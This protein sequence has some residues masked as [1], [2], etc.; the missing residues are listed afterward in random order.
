[1]QKILDI[2]QTYYLYTQI[3][4][5]ERD[6]ESTYMRVHIM[7]L[8]YITY[9][10]TYLLYYEGNAENLFQISVTVCVLNLNV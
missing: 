5:I 8:H 2:Q 3:K 6:V 9:L 4:R 1:M 7:Q 10:L